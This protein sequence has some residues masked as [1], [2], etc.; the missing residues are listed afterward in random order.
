MGHGILLEGE[1]NMCQELLLCPPALF[2]LLLPL[3]QLVQQGLGL[4]AT[5]QN[6]LLPLLIVLLLLLC[7]QVPMLEVRTIDVPN[8]TMKGSKLADNGPVLFLCP[9]LMK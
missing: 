3:L 6:L 1:N 9:H 5:I 7:H 8:L 2:Y 4:V